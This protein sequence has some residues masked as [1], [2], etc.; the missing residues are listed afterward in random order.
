MEEE[1]VL[2]KSDLWKILLQ[3]ITEG[4]YAGTSLI[5]VWNQQKKKSKEYIQVPSEA[6]VPNWSFLH[7]SSEAALF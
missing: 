3:T 6:C 7:Q 1:S 4:L 5:K 2:S